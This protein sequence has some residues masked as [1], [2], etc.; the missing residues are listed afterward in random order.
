M[1]LVFW[2]IANETAV[3]DVRNG[4]LKRIIEHCKS[5]DTTRLIT[6]AFDNMKFNAETN[7]FEL[8]DPLPAY[9][10][11]YLSISIWDGICLGRLNLQKYIGM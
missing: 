10:D 8:I 5:M 1:C 7:T 3:S 11:L 2:G 4:F 9:L 6:A